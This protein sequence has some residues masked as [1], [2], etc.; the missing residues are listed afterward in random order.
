MLCPRALKLNLQFYSPSF[1][2]TTQTKS[3]NPYPIEKLKNKGQK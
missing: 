3:G 1:L 2:T